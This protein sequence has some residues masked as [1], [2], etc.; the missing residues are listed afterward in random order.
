MITQNT[1]YP[2][3]P[4][5]PSAPLTDLPSSFVETQLLYAPVSDAN[6]ALMDQTTAIL[7]S[8]FGIGGISAHA[9]TTML[10]THSLLPDVTGFA[11][12]EAMTAFY[13]SSADSVWAGVVFNTASNYTIRMKV[14]SSGVSA[15]YATVPSTENLVDANTNC[16]SADAAARIAS[17]PA[18]TRAATARCN[19]TSRQASS[20]CR[21]LSP[22][23]M[24]LLS[25][26]T[27]RWCSSSPSWRSR[28]TTRAPSGRR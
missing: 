12:E 28:T 1:T 20:R 27:A 15:A 9:P 17:H 5:F 13:H 14:A 10:L 16:R 7:Q 23:P 4:S 24:A 21:Q 25:S 3:E 19:R 11:S 18:A 2:A 26:S 6:A 22:S 8:Q